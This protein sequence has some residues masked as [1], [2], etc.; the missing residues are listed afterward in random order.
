[1]DDEGDGIS[2]AGGILW[3]EPYRDIAQH[4]NNSYRV[5]YMA[6]SVLLALEGV[7]EGIEKRIAPDKTSKHSLQ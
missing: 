6:G 2:G 5:R 3:A 1:M 7:P 4:R